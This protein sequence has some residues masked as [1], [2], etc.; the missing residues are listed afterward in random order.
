MSRHTP[1]GRQYR[2]Q[3]REMLAGGPTCWRCGHP[4]AD[5]AGHVIPASLA[6]DLAHDPANRR[7][8]HGVIPCSTCG[9][10]CNQEAGN[11]LSYRP[12]PRSRRW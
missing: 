1:D 11:K 7:P 2:R 6:P 10:R 4:G 3:N 8:E 12:S 9:R 5:Q